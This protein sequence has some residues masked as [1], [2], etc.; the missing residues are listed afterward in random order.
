M[1]LQQV[2]IIEMKASLLDICNLKLLFNIL[3]GRTFPVAWAL[4]T[5]KTV[6]AYRDGFFAP[7]RLL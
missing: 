6:V 5:R 1:L 4:L 7:L 3:G 2:Q